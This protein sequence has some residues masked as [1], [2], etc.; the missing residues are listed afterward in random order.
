M[1]ICSFHI[2]NFRFLKFL[3]FCQQKQNNF[4]QTIYAD[5]SLPV[6]Y[7]AKKPHLMPKS[8]DRLTSLNLN[9]KGSK[10]YWHICLLNSNVL[11]PHWYLRVWSQNCADPCDGFFLPVKFYFNF[12]F[13]CSRNRSCICKCYK[14][15]HTCCIALVTNSY[16]LLLYIKV[17]LHFQPAEA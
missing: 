15:Q 1:I 4:W 13:R 10:I 2:F 17:G 5:I 6:Y 11:F 8:I 9:A 16:F 3:L 7:S 12:F 14:G